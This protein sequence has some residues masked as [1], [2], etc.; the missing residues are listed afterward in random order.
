M[1]YRNDPRKLN[2]FQLDNNAPSI[3]IEA[4]LKMQKRF[5]N[6]T[7]KNSRK[8]KIEL[9]KLQNN[10]NNKYLE[11]TSYTGIENEDILNV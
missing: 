3:K 8:S 10:I 6:L 9:E 4:Y 1:L 7:S 2:P 5:K 11:Y